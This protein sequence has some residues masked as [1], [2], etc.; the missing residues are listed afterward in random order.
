M[1]WL[2]RFL[3]RNFRI[4]LPCEG[5]TVRTEEGH[6]GTVISASSGSEWVR[7]SFDREE[8]EYFKAGTHIGSLPREQLEFVDAND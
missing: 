8:N 2:S 4:R 6:V 3:N 7:V 1:S 5:D